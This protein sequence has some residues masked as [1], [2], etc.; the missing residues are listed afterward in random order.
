MIARLLALLQNAF[1]V[2]KGRPVALVILLFLTF[3]NL[4]SEWPANLRES[5]FVAN[6]EPVLGRPFQGARKTLFDGYLRGNPRTPA[7]QP[8]TIVEIDE[9]SLAAV[10]QWPWPRNKLAALIDAINQQGPAAIGLD[11]YMP[12]PDQTSPG[13]VA[14]N[15]PANAREVARELRRLPGHEAILAESL[16]H[17]PVVL[18]AAGFGNAA[19]TTAKSLKSVPIAVG[20]GDPLRFV[21]R[22]DNVLASLPILQQAARGQ[23]LLNAELDHGV[24]RRI[25]LILGLGKD[26]IPS[27]AMEMLRVARN[28]K[29]IEVFADPNGVRKVAVAEIEVPTQRNSEVWLH[30][31]HIEDTMARYVS[32]KDVLDGK[33]DPVRLKDKM[34]LVGLTG[35]GLNELKTT[36]LG[37]LVP[38]IEIHAQMIEAMVDGQLLLRPHRLKWQ[39]T[40]FILV[41]GVFMVWYVPRTESRLATFLRNVPRASL[42]LGLV[43]NGA[44]LTMGFA[45]F[46]QTGL[47]IDAAAVFIVLSATMGSLISSAMLEIDL[48]AKQA[49]ALG[50]E[51][52]V[53]DAYQAGLAAGGNA[54]S[55]P[56]AAQGNPGQ[57]AEGTN[58]QS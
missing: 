21:L 43:L 49:A 29:A 11:V 32:A 10:G 2:G 34:V 42:V 16:G 51:Q 6:L 4:T 57:A 39:E 3:A 56:A 20:E 24:V 40:M 31:A 22:F 27:L 37:D 47:L 15:L 35:V 26:L 41:F 46:S 54:A 12:E 25:P 52:R 58:R 19:V 55:N 44:I 50:Q 23:A 38:G 30:F 8:V 5:S 33:V 45:V 48:K 36:A 1:S 17:A 14:D 13:V 53:A 28:A 18:G 9:S 7:S